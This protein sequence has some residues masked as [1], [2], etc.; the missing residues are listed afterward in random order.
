MHIFF[1]ILSTFCSV[2][3]F[4]NQCFSSKVNPKNNNLPFQ[5]FFTLKIL[6]LKKNL[7]DKK[8]LKFEKE[9]A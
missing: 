7:Y 6:G 5:I 2:T 3:Y 8:C 4:E 9:Y 1:Q